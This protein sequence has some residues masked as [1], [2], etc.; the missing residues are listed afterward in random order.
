M[1]YNEAEAT[2]EDTTEALDSEKDESNDKYV[3]PPP[4]KKSKGEHKLLE[5]LGDI[6]KF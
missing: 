3:R 4:S 6:I 2:L 1:I 5:F